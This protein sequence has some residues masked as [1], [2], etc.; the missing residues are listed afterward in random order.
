MKPIIR[1]MIIDDEPS[2][3]KS[4]S[5]DLR[6][7][8]EIEIVGTATSTE[9]VLQMILDYHPSL[10]FLDI[11]MPGKNGLELLE[12]LRPSLPSGISIVF[13]TAF[14]TYMREAFRASA[15]DYLLKPYQPE[16]LQIVID[17]VSSRPA[18][19]LPTLTE[20]PNELGGGENKRCT[21]YTPTGL[22]LVP[23][24]K[25]L[26]F[27]FIT[28]E[29]RW[30]LTLTD[31]SEHL[32][33]P[34]STANHILSFTKSFV[35]ISQDTILNI[36]YLMSVKSKPDRGKGYCCNLYPPFSHRNFFATRRYYAKLKE[37]LDII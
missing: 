6:R 31:G 17:R 21:F 13:Y 30:R 16:E 24:S 27:F 3:I 8:P 34:S 18:E 20:Y 37:M 29:R 2:C 19:Q 36:H 15:F 14:D 7:Y 10:L 9:K 5:D 32:L 25:I 22:L 35:Q 11:V 28:G 4:L 33:R 26:F 12:E 1:T 23:I